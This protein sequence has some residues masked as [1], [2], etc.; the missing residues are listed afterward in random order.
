MTDIAFYILSAM[1]I[2][3]GWRVFRVDS[4][5]RATFA[6]MVSFICVGGIA[7]LMS[8]DYI[9]IATVFMMAVEMMVMGLFMVMFMMNP[10]GLNP[11]QMVHQYR[12]SI[13]AGIV[14]FVG[15]TVAVLATDLPHNPLPAGRDTM[16]DLGIEL[17]GGSMLIFETAGVTLLATMLGA[18][19]LSSRRGRFG[20]SDDGALPPGLHPGG[21][22]AGRK[23]ETGGGHGGHGGHSGHSM[24][25]TE[26]PVHEDTGDMQHDM[27]EAVPM[28][29]GDHA[30]GHDGAAPMKH[31]HSHAPDPHKGHG[32]MPK[33][34]H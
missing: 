15:L 24:K 10:A 11:M 27:S 1:A 29:H 19:I 2:W 33:K 9:G 17:L 30:A 21:E 6:L 22:P 7:L 26:M 12:L 31:K 3:S 13:S 18:V 32:T 34:E 5:I 28:A 20:N 8:A 4:M 25:M 16:R 23:V 14:A